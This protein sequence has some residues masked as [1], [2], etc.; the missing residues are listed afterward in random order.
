MHGK[1]Y[2]ACSRLVI[3][4]GKHVSR[5][6]HAIESGTGSN[7]VQAVRGSARHQSYDANRP[8]CPGD[9]H[10]LGCPLRADNTSYTQYLAL[11]SR[12]NVI[13]VRVVCCEGAQ[14]HVA[15]GCLGRD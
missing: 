3:T 11:E 10:I 5:Y 6:W 1:T 13:S 4:I 12:G 8:E 7:R 15:H 14:D 2:N 9:G